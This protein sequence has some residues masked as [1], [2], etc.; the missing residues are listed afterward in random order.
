MYL[1]ADQTYVVRDAEL[2][3]VEYVVHEKHGLLICTNCETAVPKE[4]AYTHLQNQHIDM[5]EAQPQGFR[6]RL[7]KALARFQ[8]VDKESVTPPAP[9]GPPVESLQVQAGF[10]C[11]ACDYSCHSES[12]MTQHWK[13][14]KD[15]AHGELVAGTDRHMRCYVQQFFKPKSAFFTVIPSL[16]GNTNH[17]EYYEEYLKSI[18]LCRGPD[19][20]LQPEEQRD[21]EP[22]L[23]YLGWHEHLREQLKSKFKIRRLVEF[24]KIPLEKDELFWVLGAANRYMVEGRN[25]S[26]AASHL[27]RKKLMQ[28]PVAHDTRPWRHLENDGTLRAY[29]NGT[30]AKLCLAL[31]RQAGGHTVKD[32]RIPTTPR[33]QRAVEALK[34]AHGHVEREVECVHELMQSV[35]EPFTT[36][37]RNSKWLNVVELVLMLDSL[38]PDGHFRHEHDLTP[39]VAKWLYAL[40]NIGLYES[41]RR[42]GDMDG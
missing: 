31:L 22:L 16:A 2:D 41:R 1:A 37:Q 36:A 4:A 34:Q 28:Y 13:V 11:R 23:D 33:T 5:L 19:E 10:A 29:S 25:I 21:I 20:V 27:T 38:Y 26:Q 24:V 9:W 6:G 30:V 18:V 15:D 42:D 32:F 3:R 7:R 12:T 39:A 17:P 35:V 40:R 14:R 8:L